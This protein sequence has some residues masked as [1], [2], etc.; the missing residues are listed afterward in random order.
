MLEEHDLQRAQGH[1]PERAQGHGLERAQGHDDGGFVSPWL[2]P[3][4]PGVSPSPRPRFPSV[5]SSQNAVP[6]S[7]TSCM[8]ATGRESV[9]SGA[10]YPSSVVDS[11]SESKHLPTFLL[12]CTFLG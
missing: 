3:P 9:M 10:A 11:L 5:T 6:S 8:D 1:D 12:L 4:T 2:P 7:A